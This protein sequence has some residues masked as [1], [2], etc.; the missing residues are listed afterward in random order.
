MIGA[1]GPGWRLLLLPA[2][3]YLLSFAIPVVTPESMEFGAVVFLNQLYLL[4]HPMPLS[5]DSGKLMTA[6]TWFANPLFWFGYFAMIRGRYAVAIVFGLGAAFLAMFPPVFTYFSGKN[7][8]PEMPY[9]WWAWLA[10]TILL[11]IA[12]ELAY[13]LSP[14]RAELER[15]WATDRMKEP[16][17]STRPHRGRTRASSGL[18]P[19]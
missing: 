11:V 18:R 14:E 6:M 8:F 16:R 19:S 17:G 5:E 3:P 12:A 9:C 1:K 7:V 10:S 2:I 15:Q 13:D 4:C